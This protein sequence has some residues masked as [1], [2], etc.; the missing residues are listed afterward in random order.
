MIIAM[1]GW[2]VSPP[3]PSALDVFADPFGRMILQSMTDRCLQDVSQLLKRCVEAI[4]EHHFAYYKVGSLSATVKYVLA[5]V[6]EACRTLTLA[7]RLIQ[8]CRRRSDR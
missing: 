3:S 6:S 2:Q 5:L 8:A 7:P 1:Q 4:V